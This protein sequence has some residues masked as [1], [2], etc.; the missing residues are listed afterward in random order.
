MNA[1]LLPRAPISDVLRG[2]APL[3]GARLDPTAPRGFAS[4]I[5]ARCHLGL[6]YDGD[7]SETERAALDQGPGTFPQQLGTALKG[8]ATGVLAGDVTEEARPHVVSTRVD[9]ISIEEALERIVED[10]GRSSRIVHFVHPHALNLAVHDAALRDAL[11]KADLVL[12]DGVGLRIGAKLLG[13]PLTHNVN[14]TDLLPLLCERL[15]REQLPMCLIGAAPGV[16]EACADRLRE[17]H[18]GLKTPIV[19]HGYLEPET[20]DALVTQIRALGR[21]VVLVGMGSPRQE[22]WVRQHLADLPGVT[23]VTVGG[24]F[25]FYSDRIPRAP[26]AWRELGFEWAWRL[27]Q[28]PRRL[29]RRYLL[30]NPLFLA[31]VARQRLLA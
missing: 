26:R 7:V 20:T 2:H 27:R 18:P 21:C 6:L 22:Q 30:G 4:P 16:A 25:D 28:E 9:N 11:A 17:T 1:S 5:E 14:G 12:P 13:R 15:A 29:A 8:V 31:R 23:V 19:H 24:L 10:P 3:I